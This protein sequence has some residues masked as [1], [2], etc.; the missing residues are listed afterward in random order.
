MDN[1]KRKIFIG[2]L[3]AVIILGITAFIFLNSESSFST[4]EGIQLRYVP[5][6]Q[7]QIET[8]GNAIL[9][10][11]FIQDVPEDYPI[12]LTFYGFDGNEQVVHDTFLLGK[13]QLL[14]EGQPEIYVALDA[15]YIEK[16]QE[17]GLCDTIKEAVNNGDYQFQS[18]SGKASL[19]L[20]Y[21]GMLKHRECFGVN[22]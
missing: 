11:E 13:G 8:A 9:S 12:A 10:R 4:G 16:V 22:F 20:K 3:S 21:G 15:K 7:A 18:G 5:L 6:S 14:Q 19:L 2:I 17:K 1:K